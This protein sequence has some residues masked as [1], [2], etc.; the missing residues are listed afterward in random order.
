MV[1]ID[2]TWSSDY[3]RL[4]QTYLCDKS[5]LIF[6]RPAVDLMRLNWISDFCAK[7]LHYLIILIVRFFI[8]S[9]NSTQYI[10][11][12]S[13]FILKYS[14][15][16]CGRSNRSLNNRLNSPFSFLLANN[17]LAFSDFPLFNSKNFSNTL[18]HNLQQNSSKR[19]DVLTIYYILPI[20]MVRDPKIPP[21]K[22]PPTKIP[23]SENSTQRKFHPA[24]IRLGQVYT[25]LQ[26]IVGWNFTWVEF[27]LG[28][29]LRGWNFRGWNF[30]GWNFR[31]VEFSWV[32][33]SWNRIVACSVTTSH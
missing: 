8:S 21:T 4:R 16:L 5:I 27:S 31:W 10:R 19:T 32:E 12:V 1:T 30:R 23:P 15:N 2:A 26:S 22:I 29:I 25:T 6:M 24:K 33:F 18:Q 7:V 13:G 11:K 14:A 28:G 17:R 9:F 20:S 3:M